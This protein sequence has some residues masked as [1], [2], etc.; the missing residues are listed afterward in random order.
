MGVVYSYDN[1][2][3][4]DLRDLHEI[5]WELAD[6]YGLIK[7]TRRRVVVYVQRTTRWA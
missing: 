4:R 2:D 6:C 3:V 7:D 5:G 1:R